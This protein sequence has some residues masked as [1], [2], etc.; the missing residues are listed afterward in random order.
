MKD[1]N[2]K[3]IPHDK[4]EDENEDGKIILK[5]MKTKC[6]TGWKLFMEELGEL[7]KYGYPY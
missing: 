3:C 4:D 2:E 6:I 5:P 1:V 7:F